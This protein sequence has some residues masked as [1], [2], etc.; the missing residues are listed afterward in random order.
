MQETCFKL[1]TKGCRDF[2]RVVF[3]EC[4]ESAGNLS[5]LIMR[6]LFMPYVLL[7]K[8]LHCGGTIWIPAEAFPGEVQFMMSWDRVTY[9]ERIFS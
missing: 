1:N 3:L 9:H 2:Y 7:V 6:I 5:M 8:R 4:C